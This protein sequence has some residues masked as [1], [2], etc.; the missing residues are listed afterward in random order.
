MLPAGVQP[1]PDCARIPRIDARRDKQVAP[2]RPLA[3]SLIVGTRYNVEVCCV[4]V[5]GSLIPNFKRKYRVLARTWNAGARPVLEFC[6]VA[7]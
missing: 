7:E 4:E 6:S 3:T 5:K 1:A 2:V